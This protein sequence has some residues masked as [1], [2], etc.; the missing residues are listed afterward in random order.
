MKETLKILINHEIG[1]DVFGVNSIKTKRTIAF[2]TLKPKQKRKFP[3]KSSEIGAIYTGYS[4]MKKEMVSTY[5]EI[6]KV[7]G[8]EINTVCVLICKWISMHS[9]LLAV[10]YWKM[11]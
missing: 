9:L 1:F 7:C 6:N 5:A 4:F 10:T 8:S 3:I 11:Q 2:L